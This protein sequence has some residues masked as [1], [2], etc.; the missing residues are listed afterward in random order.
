MPPFCCRSVI[1]CALMNDLAIGVALPGERKELEALQW[2]A[3]LGNPGD[4]EALLANPDAIAVPEQQIIGGMVF[5]ARI[6]GVLVGFAA[7]I[8]RE[9]GAVELDALFVEPSA[10]RQ[11]IGRRLIDHCAAVARTRGADAI[12][13]VGNPHAD[14]F[15]RS[16]G[17][18]THAITQT[19]FGPGL[20]MRRPL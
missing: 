8:P 13:V 11:G 17:F 18:H 4:R 15:Y 20:L 14:G 19:R 9:D 16:C 7:I 10:W 6:D 3:S 12:H 1:H 5:T 2:R